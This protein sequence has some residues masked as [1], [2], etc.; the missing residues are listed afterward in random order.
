MLVAM[1]R[2]MLADG[3]LPCFLW[4]ELAYTAAYLMNHVPH[5]ALNM[6]SP[7]GRSCRIFV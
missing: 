5:S 7:F 6:E 3:E 2:C 4:G 1:I